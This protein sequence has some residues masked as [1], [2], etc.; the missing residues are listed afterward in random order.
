MGVRFPPS[1][2]ICYYKNTR[3]VAEA[4]AKRVSSNHILI[5]GEENFLI[6]PCN[7]IFMKSINPRFFKKL[8]KNFLVTGTPK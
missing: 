7:P 3:L 4:L 6:M 1:A 5:L 8:S 2:K